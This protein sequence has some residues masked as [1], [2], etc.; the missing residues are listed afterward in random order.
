[1]TLFNDTTVCAAGGGKVEP[2]GAAVGY[3]KGNEIGCLGSEQR[4]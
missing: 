3:H 1:M 4:T 2:P